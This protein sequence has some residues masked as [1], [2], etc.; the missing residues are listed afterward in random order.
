VDVQTSTKKHRVELKMWVSLLGYV[1]AGRLCE[2]M[3]L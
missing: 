2:K 3:R 1:L